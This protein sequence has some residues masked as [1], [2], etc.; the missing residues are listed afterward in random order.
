MNKELLTT[1]ASKFFSERPFSDPKRYDHLIDRIQESAL[2]E[3]SYDNI[4]VTVFDQGVCSCGWLGS[5][6]WDGGDLAFDEWVKHVVKCT[7]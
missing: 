6:F 1:S 7:S 2:P 3:H 4:G 5:N